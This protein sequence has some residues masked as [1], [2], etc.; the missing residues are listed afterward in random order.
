MLRFSN[1][2]YRAG[3]REVLRDLNFELADGQTLVLLGRSGAGKT[4]A[5]KMV[6]AL[7]MPSSGEVLVEGR[8]TTDWDPIELRRRSG[9]AIQETGLFPHFTVSQNVEIVPRLLGWPEDR[10]AARVQELLT[11]VG[12]A[13][14]QYSGR[15][16]RELS[17]GQRQRVEWLSRAGGGSSG[18]AVR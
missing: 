9:Y 5:L 17:G 10:I 12:L 13:P 7:V 18:A 16:P 3:G 1:V 14:D 6:N 8:S 15:Y 11:R 4:T 2:G